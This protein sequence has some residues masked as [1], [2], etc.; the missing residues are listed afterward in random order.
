[1]SRVACVTLPNLPIALARRDDPALAA[2]PLVLYSA[3]SRAAVYAASEDTRIAPGTPLRQ[4]RLRCPQATYL[5]AEPA[6]DHA[7]LAQLT[8]LLGAFSPRVATLAPLPDP[9]VVLDLGRLAPAHE[10]ALAAR[11]LLQI[12]AALGIAPALGLASNRRVAQHAARRAGTGLVTQLE[13]GEEAAFLAPEPITAF[14]LDPEL[15]TRL[16][17]LGLRTLGD[18]ARIPVDALQAQF[19]AEGTRLAQ[20]TRGLDAV[21]ISATSDAP[22][23]ERR[24][25][26]AGPLLDRSLLE[27]AVTTLAARLAAQLAQGAYSAG[28]LTL[29]LELDEGAPLEATRTLAEPTS[30][31]AQICQALLALCHQAEL[32]SGVTAVRV[33]A[34]QLAPLVAAQLELFAPTGGQSAQLRG[35]LDRLGGRFAGA[36]LHAELAEPHAALPEQRVRLRPR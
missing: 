10:R 4:A 12:R 24:W 34:C 22:T 28:A 30:D 33:R 7:A 20:L 5:A 25:R 2:R 6:R 29:T 17:R 35:V 32:S 8:A 13:A 31:P 26:F 9:A 21:P 1:M 36:L 27:Q 14:D 23:L 3:E 19:G 18:L 16:A 15:A 11:L